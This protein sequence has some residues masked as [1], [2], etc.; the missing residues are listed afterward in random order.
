MSAWVDQGTPHSEGK[1]EAFMDLDRLLAAAEPYTTPLA[2][3]DED[4]LKANITFMQ[5]LV[6]RA[7]AALRPHPKTHK[8]ARVAQMQLQAGAKGLTVATLREAEYFAEHGTEDL[9]LVH[10][11]VGT[12]K[13][14]RLAALAGCVPRLTVALDSIEAALQVPK[15]LELLWEVDTGHHRLGTLPGLPTVEAVQR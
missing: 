8:S 12:P 6:Q 9:L 5:E 1:Q 7:G 2:V 4:V 10:P 15:T 11:P 13:V 3:V 14:S